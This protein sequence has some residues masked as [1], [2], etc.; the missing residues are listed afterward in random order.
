MSAIEGFQIALT[1][2]ANPALKGLIDGLAGLVNVITDLM[3]RFPLLSTAVL[4]LSAAFI[5]LVAA[6]PF[7]AAFIS[8]LGSLKAALAVGSIGAAWAGIQ[9]VVIVAVA[10]MKT[11]LVGLLSWMGSTLVPG[12]LAL[13]GPA[14][15]TVLAVAAVVAMAVAFRQPIGDFLKWLPG[16]FGSAWSTIT[17][18]IARTWS[19]LVQ[20]MSNAF[21]GFLQGIRN[22]INAVSGQVNRLIR[23]FNRLNGPQISQIPQFAQG[24]FVTR[25]TLA[26]IGEGGEPEYVVPR[27]KAMTFAN[28]IVSGRRGNQALSAP[29]GRAMAGST[30]GS[31]FTPS[32]PSG[33]IAINI[34][35]GPVVEMNGQ[36]YVSYDDLER[37]MRVTVGGII[38][39]LRKPYVRQALG[40]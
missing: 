34:Q 22:S 27:S 36:R 1:T 2:G 4:A 19:G 6:A 20:S 31:S 39:G 37:A 13:M 29:P 28:N 3:K 5:G 10:G 21:N 40:R 24:G 7:I 11:A 15:W 25:P 9:T 32:G 14:G 35:T 30:A 8:L 33:P 18:A 16:A 23:A 26:M 17:N 38:G 12:I